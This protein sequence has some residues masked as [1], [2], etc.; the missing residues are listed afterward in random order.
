MHSQRGGTNRRTEGGAGGSAHAAVEVVVEEEAPEV[1][2]AAHAQAVGACGEGGAEYMKLV[3]TPL[4]LYVLQRGATE[5]SMAAGLAEEAPGRPPPR[6]W[7]EAAEHPP[8]PVPNHDDGWAFE[9]DPGHQ[10]REG[11]A[12][13]PTAEQEPP[14]LLGAEGRELRAE[15]PQVLWL[16][17]VRAPCELGKPA[18]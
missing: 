3:L 12:V 1:H 14:G 18:R 8:A 2:L 5:N 16:E 13:Q 4:D 7:R 17:K 6:H 15:C 11:A 10:A 9:E